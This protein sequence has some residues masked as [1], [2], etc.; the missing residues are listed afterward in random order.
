VSKI[1]WLLTS[2]LLL[3]LTPRLLALPEDPKALMHIIADSSQYNYKMGETWF[4]GQVKIN[5][6]STHLE[7]D[8]VITKRNAQNKIQE[9]LAFGL[10]QPA[11]Y[12]TYPKKGEKIL[13]AYAKLMKLY[14]LESRVVLEGD[15][16]VTQGENRFQGQI[17]VY[18]IKLQT[19]TVPPTKNSRA[20]FVIETNQIKQ[21][22]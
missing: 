2:L 8:R 15:V 1:K 18:N 6:G 16:R 9:A 20:T 11:H 3:L 12:W 21:T 14:P 13:H 4:E 7:A 17:I 10:R 5:Q 19:I 22:I